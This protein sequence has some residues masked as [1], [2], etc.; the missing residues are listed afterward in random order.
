[1]WRGDLRDEP[2][3]KSYLGGQ[4][5]K[6]VTCAS[7]VDSNSGKPTSLGKNIFETIGESWILD[8]IKEFLLVLL[9]IIIYD[10]YIFFK[11]SLSSRYIWGIFRSTMI[12][13]WVFFKTFQ[14]TIKKVEV[15]RLNKINNID[16]YW[17][18][19]TGI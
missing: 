9:S 6:C 16:N 5:T 18:W 1:M 7:Y 13:Y 2:V 3:C 10:G 8:N 15:E 4:T 12:W 17:G 11:M 19:E 14:V